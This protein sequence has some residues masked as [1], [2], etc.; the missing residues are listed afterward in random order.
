MNRSEDIMFYG[1]MQCQSIWTNL[2]SKLISEFSKFQRAASPLEVNQKFRNQFLNQYCTANIA[3]AENRMW[4]SLSQWSF[5]G[6]CKSCD[7]PSCRV[8]Q[9]S[10]IH[11]NLSLNPKFQILLRNQNR[12]CWRIRIQVCVKTIQIL[13]TNSWVVWSRHL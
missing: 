10:L 9:V 1:S 5:W 4:R 12:M 11:I 13:P 2:K 6:P 8:I 3:H 7:I